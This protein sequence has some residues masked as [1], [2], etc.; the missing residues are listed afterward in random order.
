MTIAAVIAALVL[1]AAAGVS[2]TYLYFSGLIKR[3]F[4]GNY[5]TISDEDGTYPVIETPLDPDEIA[6][7]KYVIFK[8][9]AK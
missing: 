9:V 4:I 5:W 2:L 6:A 7:N 3:S 8:V 1:G